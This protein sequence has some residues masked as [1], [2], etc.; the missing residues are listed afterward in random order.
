M[1]MFALHGLYYRCKIWGQFTEVADPFYDTFENIVKSSIKVISLEANFSI[2]H[3]TLI[4]Q[5]ST[6]YI[7]DAG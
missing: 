7:A 4:F 3:F 6:K 5:Y 1:K 2:Y